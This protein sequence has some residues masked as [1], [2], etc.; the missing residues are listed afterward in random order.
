M[1]L[2]KLVQSKLGRFIISVILG[3]GLATL[4]RKSCKTKECTIFLPPDISSIK[5]DVFSYD[6]KC[7]KYKEKAVKCDNEHVIIEPK[8]NISE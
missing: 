7:V 6:N 8:D 2:V 5:D 1:N 4:F 3:L